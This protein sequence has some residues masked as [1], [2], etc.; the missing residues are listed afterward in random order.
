MPRFLTL[1]LGAL[2][3]FAAGSTW[4][5]LYPPVLADTAGIEEPSPAPREVTIVVAGRGD[6][7]A[8]VEPGEGRAVVVLLHGHA[9]DERRLRRHAR[10]LVADG[11]AVVAVRFRSAGGWTR[12]PATLG[13]HECVDV[14]AVLDWV[15]SQPAW[16]GRRVAILGESL[17]AS[18]ALAV[19]AERPDVA[20]VV[21]DDPFARADWAIEDRVRLEYHLP[22]WPLVPL[23]RAVA[24]R[25]TGHDPGALDVTAAMRALTDRPVLL[26][27]GSLEDHLASRHAR[28]LEA[29]AGAA[30]ECWTVE[31]AGHAGSWEH[32]RIAYERRVRA[33]LS[34]ALT[35]RPL[36]TLERDDAGEGGR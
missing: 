10:Y 9:R 15:A 29:A 34:R 21:A 23:A 13:A 33:F 14:R 19:A 27:R 20:A 2:L 24:R 11:Y 8:F 4:L 32:D 26:I 35:G 6:V 31:G 36:V 22:A 12:R 28:A 7:R 1:A 3:L 16:R 17:G 5:A 25:L 30:A 18:V